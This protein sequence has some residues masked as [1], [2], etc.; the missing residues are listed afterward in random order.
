MSLT[1]L[2]IVS[3]TDQFC[4]VDTCYAKWFE[5]KSLQCDDDHGVFYILNGRRFYV[6]DQ[7][8][9]LAVKDNKKGYPPGGRTQYLRF[10]RERADPDVQHHCFTRTKRG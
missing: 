6:H 3:T 1:K 8:M 7:V 4:T 5:S 10:V 2:P 9:A